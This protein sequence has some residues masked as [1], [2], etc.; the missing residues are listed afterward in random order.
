MTTVSSD[1]L[2]FLDGVSEPSPD[3]VRFSAAD[4]SEAQSRYATLK[5]EHPGARVV[6]DIDVHIA[7]DAR[8]ARREVLASDSKPR[9][10]TLQYVGTASGLAGLVADI[11]TVDVADGVTLRPVVEQTRESVVRAITTEVVP[12][13][14]VRRLRAS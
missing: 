1:S 12:A 9:P 4:L 6:V 8:T 3:V 5:A 2:V 7:A 13:L 10:G 11:V 14:E